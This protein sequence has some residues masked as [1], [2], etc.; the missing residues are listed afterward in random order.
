MAT[1]N[2]LNV[3]IIIHSNINSPAAEGGG[4][5]YI[6]VY[7]ILLTFNMKVILDLFSNGIVGFKQLNKGTWIPGFGLQKKGEVVR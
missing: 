5:I 2:V 1:Q 3:N 6:M 7:Y 4:G